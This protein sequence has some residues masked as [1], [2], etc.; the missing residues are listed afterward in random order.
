MLFPSMVM[1]SDFRK[2]KKARN[3]DDAIENANKNCSSCGISDKND[4]QI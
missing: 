4:I 1:S 3:K 2:K